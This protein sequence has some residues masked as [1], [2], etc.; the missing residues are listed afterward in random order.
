M[1]PEEDW[2]DALD[3]EEEERKI[4]V[5]NDCI[6]VKGVLQRNPSFRTMPSRATFLQRQHLN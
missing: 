3:R 5:P 6:W 4:A 2:L 1:A